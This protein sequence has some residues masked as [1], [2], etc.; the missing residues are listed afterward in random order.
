MNKRIVFE[1]PSPASR[2][3][4]GGAVQ[5]FIARLSETPEKWAV[6]TREAKFISYYYSL[7]SQRNDLKVSVRQNKD[8][9]T[10]T[11]YMMVLSE[12]GIKS[13]VAEKAKRSA[14]KATAPKK[15]IA[16]KTIAKKTTAK[17]AQV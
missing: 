2:G 13:R 12:A 4:S 16:K 14:K 7:A 1:N 8:G 10:F 9:K 11:V 5:S 17:K 15:V 3:R 6:Y